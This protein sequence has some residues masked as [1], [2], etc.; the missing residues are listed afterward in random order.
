VSPDG[1]HYAY[2]KPGLDKTKVATM[3]IVDVA[4]GRD[5][6]FATPSTDWF[7]PYGVMD[8][9]SDGVYL[10]T[11]Y[12]VSHGLA[13]MSPQTGVIKTVADLV[14]IQASAGNKTFWVG[15]VNPADPHPNGGIGIQPNQI[16][17]FSLVDRT[18]VE[19]FYRPSSSPLV[20]GS[21]TQGHPFV[22]AVN[23]RN[24][25]IDGDYGAELLL[26][27]S[28]QSWQS[29]FKGSAKLFGSSSISTISDSH[30]TWFGSGQGIYLYTGTA[31]IKVSN[32]PGYPANGCF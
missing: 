14:Y 19:W 32:Q 5:H 27:R 12:E 18:R 6:V 2:G 16:D 29:I 9:A 10:F 7:V 25:V 8:Y 23:G 11:N 21:D 31:L 26:L 22:W 20:I 30:G 17:R 13:L 1:K 24:G 15:S 28:P 4:T 3:H